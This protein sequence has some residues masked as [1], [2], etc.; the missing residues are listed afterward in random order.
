M[1]FCDDAM[2]T[3]IGV[4][5][6]Q[7]GDVGEVEKWG[8]SKRFWQEEEWCRDVDSFVWSSDGH[9]LFVATGGIYGTG[10]TYALNL[11]EREAIQIFPKK[12]DTWSHG[13]CQRTTVE[14][15]NEEGVTL[16]AVECCEDGEPLIKRE[17]VK[18]P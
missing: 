1:V 13:S 11:K 9:T 5:L 7:L 6:T 8:S 15:I 16:I 2:G 12:S 18:Y 4:V 14:A 10:N 3:T 17:V